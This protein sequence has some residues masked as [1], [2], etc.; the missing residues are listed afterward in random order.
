MSLSLR[1]LEPADFELLHRWLNELHL[2]PFYIA[3]AISF[4]D[5]ASKYASRVGDQHAAKGVIAAE[6]DQPFGYMQWYLNR[7]YPE[8]GAAIIG[9]TA[10]VTIDYLIGERRFLGRSLGS[11]MLKALVQLI[12]PELDDADRVFHIGHDNENL[13]AIRCTQRAGFVADGEFVENG[14]PSTLFV[15]NE[16]N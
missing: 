16:A 7:S 11:K 14:R 6:D 2:R 9:R 13:R 4:E 15:R 8:Y 3:E 12:L 1:P 10:G 5:V